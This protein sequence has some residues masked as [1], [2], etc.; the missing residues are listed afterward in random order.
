MI[1]RRSRTSSRPWAGRI[2]GAEN[3]RGRTL[4]FQFFIPVGQSN[5]SAPFHA[6][7][8]STGTKKQK[9]RP[10]PP[11]PKQRYR[12]LTP[13]FHL[14]KVAELEQRAESLRSMPNP[15]PAQFGQCRQRLA[16]LRQHIEQH[17]DAVPRNIRSGHPRWLRRIVWPS[18]SRPRSA[19][20]HGVH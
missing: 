5:S 11:F 3:K 14:K 7:L 4:C 20:N 15:L 2:N 17:R 12:F 13:L 1:R 18:P 6:S 19:P 9:K 16:M 8:R 10:A